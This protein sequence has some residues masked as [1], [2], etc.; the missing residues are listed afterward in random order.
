MA[1]VSASNP[2]SVRPSMT[3]GGEVRLVVGSQSKGSPMSWMLPSSE[4]SVRSAPARKPPTGPR[5]GAAQSPDSSIRAS[6][7]RERRISPVATMRVMDGRGSA[8]RPEIASTESFPARVEPVTRTRSA[9]GQAARSGARRGSTPSTARTGV[10]GALRRLE[11][12]RRMA[13][14]LGP[15]RRS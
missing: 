11:V 2:A 7:Q 12:S 14:L 8:R 1:R 13:P 3:S 9:N 4:P 5:N 10:R 15:R 6:V